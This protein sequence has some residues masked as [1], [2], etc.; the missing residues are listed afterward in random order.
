MISRTVFLKKGHVILLTKIQIYSLQIKV[1]ASF[2]GAFSEHTFKR[3][4]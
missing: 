3:K 1:G 4:W 2:S